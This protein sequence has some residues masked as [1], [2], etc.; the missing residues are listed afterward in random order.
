MKVVKVF[1]FTW[2]TLT[3]IYFNCKFSLIQQEILLQYSWLVSSQCQ[4]M[5]M[6][7][8][9]LFLMDHHCV[10][11]FSFAPLQPGQTNG[12]ECSVQKGYVVGW[13]NSK[14]I[15]RKTYPRHIMCTNCINLYPRE[16]QTKSTSMTKI[17]KEMFK[18]WFTFCDEFFV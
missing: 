4:I 11:I 12:T 3:T 15:Q 7:L 17:N 2:S 1:G 8:T 14:P 9:W 5:M 10:R 13:S 16:I 18:N 6:K